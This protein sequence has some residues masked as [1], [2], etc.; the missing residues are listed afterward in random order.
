ME[1]KR[2]ILLGLEVT[3]TW[4]VMILNKSKA[5]FKGNFLIK[6]SV[7]S[8]KEMSKGKHIYSINLPS[9][10]ALGAYCGTNDYIL[11]ILKYLIDK[12]CIHSRCTV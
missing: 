6:Q 8:K 5:D 9:T 4:H 7:A 1:L 3:P 10:K 2:T 11:F 12:D